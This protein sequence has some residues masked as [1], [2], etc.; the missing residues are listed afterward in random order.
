MTRV[1][2]KLLLFL[3]SL[4]IA[5]AA[6]LAIVYTSGYMR[7]LVDWESVTMTTIVISVSAV[8]LLISLRFLY[9]SLRVGG[10]QPSSIDQRTDYGDIRISMETIEN[11]TLKAAARVKGVKDLKVRANVNDSGLD[12]TV[13]A[14]MD[15]D[16]SIPTVTEDV[17]RSVKQHLEE[18][19]GIPVY[20]V[21]V[22]VANIIQSQTFKSR[23]E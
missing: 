21:S 11:L 18:T 7:G 13:R 20:K 14:I 1:V 22:Y 12:L 5:V 23:V 6:V 8:I 3:Y 2:D 9:I 15:G 10:G 4:A 16:L 17:Q 19:T